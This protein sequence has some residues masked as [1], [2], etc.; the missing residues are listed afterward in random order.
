LVGAYAINFGFAPDGH[1]TGI[2]S[3]DSLRALATDV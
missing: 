1:H 3:F 2:Y